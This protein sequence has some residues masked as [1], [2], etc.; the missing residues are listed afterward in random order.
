MNRP[1]DHRHP[2]YDVFEKYLSELTENYTTQLHDGLAALYD[3]RGDLTMSDQE[4]TA[5]DNIIDLHGAGGW[6]DVSEENKNYILSI[7]GG[8]II[9][10]A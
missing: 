1:K 4:K 10:V 5:L 7:T 3:I 2:A 9:I 6:F 8:A